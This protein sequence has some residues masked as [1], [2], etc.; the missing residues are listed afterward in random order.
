MRQ[1][2]TWRTKGFISGSPFPREIAFTRANETLSAR[3]RNPG[4]EPFQVMTARNRA[5]DRLWRT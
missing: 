5:W 2:P 4:K 3:P 1:P